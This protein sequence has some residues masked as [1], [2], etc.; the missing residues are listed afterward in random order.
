MTRQHHDQEAD[1][2]ASAASGTTAMPRPIAV[3]VNETPGSQLA[4]RWAVEAARLHQR[5]LKVI[6]VADPAPASHY[7]PY[8]PP[9]SSETFVLQ[10]PSPAHR[11]S[12]AFERA[13]AYAEDRLPADAVTGVHTPGRTTAVLI[14]A[15]RNAGMLVVGSRGRS[16]VS[17]AMLGSV[18]ATVAARASCPV[19]V[20]RSSDLVLDG[21]RR[22]VVGVD[23]SQDSE[24]A[25]E[26]AFREASVRKLPVTVVHC[27]ADLKD[28][29]PGSEAIF[30]RRLPAVVRKLAEYREQWPDVNATTLLLRGDPAIRLLEESLGAELLVV[31]SRGRGRI[32]GPLLGSVSQ[33]LL[34]QA[35]CPVV[36]AHRQEH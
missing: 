12:E 6:L 33:D 18:S 20:V 3:G 27:W 8:T 11:T 2:R 9:G 15:S 24:D 17:A 1:A 32:S 16:A 28:E 26:I 34:R 29:P 25:L 4:L 19:T 10:G 5:P 23:G 21:H 13:V 22:V 30:G 35:H 7:Y 36:V 14:D 31:G